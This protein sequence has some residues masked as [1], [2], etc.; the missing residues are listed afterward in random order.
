MKYKQNF[1]STTAPHNFK[2]NQK[3]WLSDT[4]ALGKNPKLTPKW[5]GPYK[6]VDLNDNNAKLEIKT[7][8]F[9]VVNCSRLKPF[10]ISTDQS[11]C[12]EESR[13]SQG[14]PSLFED[15][16]TNLPNR[17]LT[18]ALKKLIDYKNAATMAISLL[19]NDFECPYTFTKNYTQFCC[20]KCYK[21]FKDMDFSKDPNACSKHKN[22]NT[23]FFDN[24][25]NVHAETETTNVKTSI[26]Q[27]KNNVHSK[28]ELINFA[29]K[30]RASANSTCALIK[31]KKYCKN[32]ADPIKISA[33]KEGLRLKLTSIASK[34]LSSDDFHF[35]H[36][37]EEEQHL[38]R[39]FDK[40]EIYKFI[41]GEE[42][43]LP[44]FQYNWIEP[45][46]LAVHLPP[47]LQRYLRD[48]LLP[49]DQQK[50]PVQPPP[51]P[52]V[53]P[54]PQVQPPAA[55]PAPP[56]PPLQA[57]DQ[58]P[59]PGPSGSQAGT[60]HHQ[61]R[62]KKAIDYKELHT[63]IKHRCRKLRR[64]AKTVVT[65]LAPGAFSPKQPPPGSPSN[66]GPSS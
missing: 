40:E 53:L 32:D 33:I 62:P 11:V 1:D 42:D 38:W 39:Q 3:V 18:R 25:T 43:T 7:N 28:A 57:Q 41:T 6:I 36:L 9:K 17:P 12:P 64:Q 52:P 55:P 49:P 59:V 50:V 37:S 10:L 2:I 34:L 65:K 48:L 35:C 66:Q 13:L 54:A 44:E 61:L 20:D 16:N 14:D 4:T 63:G 23:S 29:P 26:S 60:Q 56:A 27:T 22:L 8:K 15:T 31:H 58:Q 47:E 51:D 46:Q 19:Q 30:Q 5:L 24:K 45:C 21:A